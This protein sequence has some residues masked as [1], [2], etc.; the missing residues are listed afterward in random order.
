MRPRID[1][2]LGISATTSSSRSRSRSFTRS[3]KA[4]CS[5]RPLPYS[6]FATSQG[7]ALKFCQHPPRFLAGQHHRNVARA[8][9]P[10]NTLQPGQIDLQHMTVEKEAGRQR[11]VL[12][13]GSHPPMHREPGKKPLDL[14]AATLPRMQTLERTD[15]TTHPIQVGL[16]S[17]SWARLLSSTP[18]AYSRL[19][20]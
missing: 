9:R 4:S 17:E 18:V 2:N 13:R 11:L 16:K 15:V 1:S 14:G 5:R 3:I 8:S 19:Q 20:C 12:R 10:R 7:V 6:K